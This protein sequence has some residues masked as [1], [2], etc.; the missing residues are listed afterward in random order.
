M[1]LKV[2]LMFFRIFFDAYP[3]AHK[4]ENNEGFRKGINDA[5]QDHKGQVIG[6]QD[7]KFK[8]TLEKTGYKQQKSHEA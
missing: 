3:G 5:D 7:F 1:K 4:K 6:R 2:E 8:K